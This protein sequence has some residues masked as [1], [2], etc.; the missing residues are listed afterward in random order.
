MR[1]FLVI[2][3]ETEEAR[4]AL[5]YA[6]RRA[7]ATHGTVQILA[8]VEPQSF[9]AFGGVQATIEKEA[10]DRA[11]AIAT[12]A[13]GNLFSESGRMPAISVEVGDGNTVVRGY[14]ETHPE[15]T[16]LVLSAAA[17]GAPGPLV[18]H[19]S[20]IVGALSCPVVFLPGRLSFEEIDRLSE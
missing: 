1:T 8:L 3:D 2:I 18:S 14:L 16:M 19:F 6:S 7:E 11:E 9:N 20:Q 10:R 13:A 12:S 4:K 5:R 15:V 17:E